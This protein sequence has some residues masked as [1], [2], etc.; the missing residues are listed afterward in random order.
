MKITKRVR[1]LAAIVGS[2]IV[3]ASSA[4]G[5]DA[6]APVPAAPVTTKTAEARS[7]FVPTEASKALVGVTDGVYT[8]TFNP[9]ANQSFALGPNR[10]VIPANA[11]CQFGTSGYGSAYWN[12]PCTPETRPVTLTVTVKNASSSN[13]Q[14]DFR[15]AMRFNPQT[16]VSIYFYVPR[17]TREDQKNW[18]IL[19]C[20]SS[21]SGS[22]SGSTSGSGSGCVDESVADPS[23]RSF[24][25]Y[26]ASVLFRR[27][28][29]FSVYRVDDS[30]YVTGG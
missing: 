28:K 8:V 13:P 14:V 17:V 23:L 18:Q 16:T 30:G 7:G 3:V 22:S 26:N 11:V 20:G 9:A 24:I 25:D 6:T 19:Y 4:C 12:K 10:L 15:P 27:I 5:P 1:V 29:H 21:Y 2:G